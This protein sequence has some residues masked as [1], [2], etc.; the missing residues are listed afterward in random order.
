MKVTVDTL[1]CQCVIGLII[2]YIY[3]NVSEKIVKR[4]NLLCVV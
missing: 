3:S 1:L 2:Y 4:H